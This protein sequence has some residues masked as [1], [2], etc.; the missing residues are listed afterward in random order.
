MIHNS[1]IGYARIPV[2]LGICIIFA[3][4]LSLFL[5]QLLTVHSFFDE[6]EKRHW[7]YSSLLKES[8]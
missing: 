3:V 4:G 8:S 7:S 1:L 2:L 5:S 6:G